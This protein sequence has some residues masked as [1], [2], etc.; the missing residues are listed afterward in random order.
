MK[1][2]EYSRWVPPGMREEGCL[3]LAPNGY[4]IVLALI[5]SGE[6]ETGLTKKN[7]T[8]T[9]LRPGDLDGLERLFKLKARNGIPDQETWDGTGTHRPW[10]WLSGFDPLSEVEALCDCN[11]K[12][13]TLESTAKMLAFAKGE[14]L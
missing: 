9:D 7:T 6:P 8:F 3:L 2:C 5:E 1:L 13:W 10:L 11:S 14:E 4:E 12:H